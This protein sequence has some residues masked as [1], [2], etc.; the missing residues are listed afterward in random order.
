MDPIISAQ[1]KELVDAIPVLLK[2]AYEFIIKLY[3]EK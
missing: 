3:I 1:D 2:I